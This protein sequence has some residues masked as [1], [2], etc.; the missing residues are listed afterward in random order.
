MKILFLVPDGVGIRN[1]L[2]SNLCKE[3]ISKGFEIQLYHKVSKAALLEIEDVCLNISKNHKR[4]PDLKEGFILRFLREAPAYARLVYFSKVLKNDSIK[5][6]W[7]KK[8]KTLKMKL[9]YFLCKTIGK[10]MSINYKLIRFFEKRYEILTTKTSAYKNVIA[11][12]EE[13]KPDFIINLHQRAPITTPVIM[14]AKALG[15]KNSTVIFSWDN[16]PKARLISR[17]QNYF[18]WSALMKKQLCLLYRE[19][20]PKNVFVVGSPQFEFHKREEFRLTK[21]TFF[22][23]YKLNSNK[24]TICFS[25]DDVMTSPYDQI[26]LEDLCDALLNFKEEDRPQIIFRR[27]PVDFSTRFD[28]VLE[29]YKHIITVIHPDWRVE[30]ESEKNSFSLIYPS[31]NDLKLLVNTCLHSDLVINLGSTMAHD[32]AV[33]NKPC[34]Y[35]NYNPKAHKYWSVKKTYKYEHFRSMTGLDAVGW[36]NSAN[37]FYPLIKRILKDKNSVGKDREIWLKKIVNYPIEKNAFLLAN[38]IISEIHKN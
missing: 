6:F 21:E 1:Y 30:K 8:P 29:K 37:D 20:N 16:V 22:K 2:Y 4:L 7:S 13:I 15:I 33:H 31:Y 23:E 25:G 3:L 17:P 9:F 27:C 32:F 5:F 36:V 24:K 12:L 11:D 26:F 14:A 38:T 34:L 28:A 19:I 35:L 10:L 18:V